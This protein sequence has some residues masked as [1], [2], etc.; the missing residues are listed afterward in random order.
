MPGHVRLAYLRLPEPDVVEG[1]TRFARFYRD[2]AA[3]GA[4]L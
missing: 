2:E 1:F 3:R 4:R